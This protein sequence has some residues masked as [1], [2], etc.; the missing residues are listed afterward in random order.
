MTK[1]LKVDYFVEDNWDVVNYLS[2]TF[3][4]SKFKTEVWWISNFLDQQIDYP[5]K[6]L[7]FKAVIEDLKKLT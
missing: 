3:K 4:K 1:K 2:Q 6:Y 5:H 7:S